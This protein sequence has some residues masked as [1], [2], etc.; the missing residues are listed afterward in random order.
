[1]QLTRKKLGFVALALLALGGVATAGGGEVANFTTPTTVTAGQNISAG[2]TVTEAPMS[3]T[4]TSSP[5][6]LVNYTTTV[7]SASSTVSIPTDGGAPAGSYILTARPTTGRSVG[8][9]VNT[10]VVPGN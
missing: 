2:V 7:S 6:G 1:M 3:V 9:S 5:A 4:F 10:A 8:I